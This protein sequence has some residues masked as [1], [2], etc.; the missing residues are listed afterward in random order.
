MMEEAKVV[1]S[2]KKRPFGLNTRTPKKVWCFAGYV[3]AS[4]PGAWGGG[5][6]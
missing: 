5:G 1:K 4:S 6:V 2:G 3:G